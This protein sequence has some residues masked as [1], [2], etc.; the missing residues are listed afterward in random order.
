MVCTPCIPACVDILVVACPLDRAC[1]STPPPSRINTQSSTE[2]KLVAAED[3]MPII[4]WTNYF[5]NLQG[6]GTTN[7]IL[8]QESQSA[9]HLEK[10][11]G[12]SSSKRIKHLN[13]R[14][15][16]ITDG[17][18]NKELSVEYCPTGEMVG[19]FFT[20]PLQGK[21]FY[22]FCYLVMNS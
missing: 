3:F 20:K 14:Y 1:L 17:I 6:Y 12:K 7:T 13:C 22:K 5:L 11:G 4:L 16:F 10:N 18:N 15:Y 8:Y 21:L 19:D 2:T 9:I